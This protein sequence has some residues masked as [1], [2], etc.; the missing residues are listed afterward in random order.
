MDGQCRAYDAPTIHREEI[1]P[2]LMTI[3]YQG[4]VTCPECDVELGVIDSCFDE[5]EM[6]I[7]N[8]A[9]TTYVGELPC[10]ACETTIYRAQ[11]RKRLVVR[12]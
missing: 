4:I 10:P 7:N 5:R 9:M 6:E 8:T 3:E 2:L 12:K 11:R 1:I